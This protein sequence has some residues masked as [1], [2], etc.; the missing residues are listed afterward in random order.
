M[1]FQSA[2]APLAHANLGAGVLGG[3]AA[4]APIESGSSL[5]SSLGQGVALRQALGTLGP[6][7][8]GTIGGTLTSGTISGTTGTIGSIGSGAHTTVAP[9]VAPTVAHTNVLASG[10]QPLHSLGGVSTAALGVLRLR[11]A[12]LKAKAGLAGRRSGGN[13]GENVKGNDEEPGSQQQF[14]GQQQFG[15]QQQSLL[16]TTAGTL[17]TAPLGALPAL[18]SSELSQHPI[19]DTISRDAALET[20]PETAE[21]FDAFFAA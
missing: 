5:R 21:D 16:R 19:L 13:V 14:G 20:F 3:T 10:T 15:S 12:T 11:Q 7:T 17:I 18:R 4:G 1:M 6:P 8:P 2:L 9:T